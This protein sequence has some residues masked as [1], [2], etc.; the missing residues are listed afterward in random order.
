M[1]L[2]NESLNNFIE[3]E[4]ISRAAAFE[5]SGSVEELKMMLKGIAVKAAAIL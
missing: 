3:E 4:F 5:V 2:F 1:Q